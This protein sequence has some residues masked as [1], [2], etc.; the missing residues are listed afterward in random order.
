MKNDTSTGLPLPRSPFRASIASRHGGA[1][2]GLEEEPFLGSAS[3][4]LRGASSVLALTERVR[5]LQAELARAGE[6][7]ERL[8]GQ[9]CRWVDG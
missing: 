7:R 5:A 2:G 9:V 1:R 3:Q 8:K 6:E 4:S